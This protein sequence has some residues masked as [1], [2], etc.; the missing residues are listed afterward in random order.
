MKTCSTAWR[1]APQWRDIYGNWCSRRTDQVHSSVWSSGTR[2]DRRTDERISVC[3]R[4]EECPARIEKRVKNFVSRQKDFEVHSSVGWVFL[5]V[6]GQLLL[7]HMVRLLSLINS[8]I[9]CIIMH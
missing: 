5:K 8:A 3:G 4:R 2:G 7:F 1:K 6:D 9:S